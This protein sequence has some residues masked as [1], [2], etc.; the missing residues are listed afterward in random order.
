MVVCSV[1]ASVSTV[2]GDRGGDFTPRGYEGR[3]QTVGFF[4]RASSS[5]LSSSTWRASLIASRLS[6]YKTRRKNESVFCQNVHNWTGKK[7]ES[8][9]VELKKTD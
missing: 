8:Q 2:A 1:K 5:S 6:I 3:E 9:R 4:Q 7:V